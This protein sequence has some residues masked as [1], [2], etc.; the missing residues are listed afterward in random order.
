MS[1]KSLAD[2]VAA[3]LKAAKEDRA[4]LDDLIAGLVLALESQ[5]EAP[6]AKPKPAQAN[7]RLTRGPRARNGE[8]EKAVLAA[9]AHYD[10]QKVSTSQIAKYLNQ[11]RPPSLQRKQVNHASWLNRA[12][13]TLVEMMKRHEV[14]GNQIPGRGISLFWS[15]T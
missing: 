5:T 3:T 2:A 9:M 8:M 13:R 11:H 14:D 4:K 6:K 15:R 12:N 10:G 7:G 1:S